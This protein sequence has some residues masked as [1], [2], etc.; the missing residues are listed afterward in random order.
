MSKYDKSGWLT[1]QSLQYGN[2]HRQAQKDTGVDVRLRSHRLKQ[3]KV[4]VIEP[5][6]DNIKSE[7]VFFSLPIAKRRYR[8]LIGH[9]PVKVH[10]P[11]FNQEI[12]L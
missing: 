8:E 4:E 3:Y 11:E 2:Q 12:I 10:S 7:E 9:A 5:V 6:T 1:P